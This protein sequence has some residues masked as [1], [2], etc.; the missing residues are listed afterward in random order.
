M[1]T[2][3]RALLAP[4]IFSI[5]TSILA[6]PEIE[7]V[8]VTA[9]RLPEPTAIS[10][11]VFDEER[12]DRQHS[13]DVVDLL[14]AAPGVSATQPGGP[15]G[16]SEVFL[17][18]AE[19]NFTV[20]L[21]D[22][23]RVN[24]PSN[25][26]GGGYDFSTLSSGDI[27]RIEIAHSALSAV[28]GSDAMAGVINIVTTRPSAEP[29]LSV[30]VEGGGHDFQRAS[31][32]LSGPLAGDAARGSLKGSYVDFGEAVTGTSQR[33]ASA[34]A[35]LELGS[36][37]SALGEIRT[38]VRY[39]ER[40]RT[41]F[42]DA[43][44]G[45]RYA[46]L[47]ESE[48]GEADETSAWLHSTRA[49]NDEWSMDT[50]VSFFSRREETLTPAIAPGVFE[51]VPASTNDSRFKRGQLTV[52]QRYSPAES[53]ELGA[54]VDLQL[55]EGERDGE[56]D[57][58][59]MTLPSDFDLD[60]E[61]RAAFAEARY[62]GVAGFELHGAAR[63]DDT[64]S[65]DAR[66]SGRVAASYAHAPSST[67]FH[68][69]WSNGHKQPSFYALGDTLVGNEGLRVE[70]SETVEIGAEKGFSE[71]R[72]IGGLTAFRSRYEDLIDFDFATFR[73]MNR[74]EARIDGIEVSFTA[75]V[76]RAITARAHATLSDIELGDEDAVLLYRPEQYGGLELGWQLG[77]IWSLHAHAQVIGKR[78]GSS[79][80]TGPVTLGSYERLDLAV[81][82]TISEAVRMF[83]AVDNVLDEDY[84]EAVGFPDAGIQLRLGASMRF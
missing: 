42:P 65:D 63:V 10:L 52:T 58:G 80:P 76:T 39:V 8:L 84:E 78:E 75:H 37:D 3:A 34:Q 45:P 74:S 38:G 44:G 14:R 25:P 46:V 77:D 53:I 66:T 5:S 28:H 16:F 73:L 41:S 43:S 31:A 40:D 67:R 27:E 1:R 9:S 72:F 64:D 2:L 79:V 49:F 81:S 11:T 50:S 19:S 47:R 23:V 18:G 35:D 6:Q 55:E 4:T 82:R 56:I 60:R 68:A 69:T 83:A 7:P 48:R 61:A 13:R 30:S 51:G 71:G 29:A 33:I 32:S 15:G 54:G 24:D 62:K 57:L 26:R 36:V 70:T 59:F 12:I 22:G 21:I 20:V 17:R